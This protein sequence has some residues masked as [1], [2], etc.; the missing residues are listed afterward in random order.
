[1][2]LYQVV[3]IRLLNLSAHLKVELIFKSINWINHLQIK[4]SLD[5][6]DPI[7]LFKSS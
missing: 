3:G 2:E 6:V 7:K 1:M 5:K 4:V